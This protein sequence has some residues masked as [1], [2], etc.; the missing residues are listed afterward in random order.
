MNLYLIACV[1]LLIISLASNA[2]LL[3]HDKIK[4]LNERIDSIA[5]NP[6]T[7]DEIRERFHIFP[8]QDSDFRN[9]KFILFG[10]QHMD[11]SGKIALERALQA[12]IKPGDILLKEGIARGKGDPCTIHTIVNLICTEEWEAQ[13]RAYDPSAFDEHCGSVAHR[14]IRRRRFL[15]WPLVAEGRANP[16]IEP[17]VL[18]GKV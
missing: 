4:E 1:K 8:S 11:A 14:V 10:E 17:R 18:A 16:F 7:D 5:D 3:E 12:L 15:A 6:M 2:S 9:A 13:H